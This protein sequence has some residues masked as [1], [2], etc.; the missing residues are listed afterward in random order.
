MKKSNL[1]VIEHDLCRLWSHSYSRSCVQAS[2]RLASQVFKTDEHHQECVDLS[3]DSIL[4]WWYWQRLL[5]HVMVDFT[6]LILWISIYDLDWTSWL[7][8]H[9]FTKTLQRLSILK[10]RLKGRA[11]RYFLAIDTYNCCPSDFV[12]LFVLLAC[13]FF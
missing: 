10:A 9:A 2:T 8:Y 11:N 12:Y 3:A 1:S 13:F 4:E 7:S 6:N 5:K